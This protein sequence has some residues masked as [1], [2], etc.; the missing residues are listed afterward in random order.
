MPKLEVTKAFKSGGVRYEIGDTAELTDAIVKGLPAG[1]VRPLK[2]EQP[3]PPQAPEGDAGGRAGG[4]PEGNA[5]GK[6]GK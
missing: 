5:A 3:T 4:K 2:A 1:L 6:A